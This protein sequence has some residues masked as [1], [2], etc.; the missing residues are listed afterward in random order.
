M[1]DE[2][3]AIYEEMTTNVKVNNRQMKM[4]QAQ[5]TRIEKKLFTEQEN[6]DFLLELV[7]DMAKDPRNW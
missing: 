5:F 1:K 3:V 6:R 7:K 2:I 4:I